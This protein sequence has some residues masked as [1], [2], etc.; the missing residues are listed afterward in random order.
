MFDCTAGFR[1]FPQ[2]SAPWHPH[3]KLTAAAPSIGVR[4]GAVV[5]FCQFLFV[6]P[7]R[8]LELGL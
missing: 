2:V 6:S 1:R 5:R 3:S 4:G 7:H 8:T